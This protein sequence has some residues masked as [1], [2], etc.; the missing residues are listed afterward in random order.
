M[1]VALSSRSTYCCKKQYRCCFYW[2]KEEILGIKKG[3]SR[4][5]AE[6]PFLFSLISSRWLG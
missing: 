5:F 4:K 3:Y 6:V 2:K 1:L